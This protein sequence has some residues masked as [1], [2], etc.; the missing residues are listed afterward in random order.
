MFVVVKSLAVVN[1]H[2][3]GRNEP[4]ELKANFAVILIFSPSSFQSL[5]TRGWCSALSCYF[6]VLKAIFNLTSLMT[7]F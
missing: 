7:K 6:T 2:F 1:V 4:R 5:F 3:L